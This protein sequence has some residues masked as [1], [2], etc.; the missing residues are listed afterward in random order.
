MATF[1]AILNSSGRMPSGSKTFTENGQ[2][3]VTWIEG[4]T[5]DVY[6]PQLKQP[7]LELATDDYGY[8]YLCVPKN[9]NY[10]VDGD[11]ANYFVVYCDGV[12]V[13]GFLG[14]QGRDYYHGAIWFT[15]RS[16]WTKLSAGQHTLQ[17]IAINGKD[18]SDTRSGYFQDSP[19]SNPVYCT[20]S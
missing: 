20:K 9:Y 6:V 4:A 11:H 12:E 8:Q 2:Y 13:D 15:D 5:V 1:A 14:A 17:V 19:L 16:W 7:L 3:D 10:N 18:Y